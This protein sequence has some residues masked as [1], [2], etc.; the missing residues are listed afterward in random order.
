[1]IKENNKY[2]LKIQ[3]IILRRKKY[4][5][6]NLYNND[7]K[8]EYYENIIKEK[9]NLIIELKEKIKLLEKQI[10]NKND[11]KIN[12]NW[13]DYNISLKNSIHTLNYHKDWVF[14]LSV[15]NDGRLITGSDDCSL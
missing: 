13:N 6:I 12:N 1:M 4:L 8:K 2:K 15:L 7:N 14:C 10:N 9:D 11:D 5:Y 3:F